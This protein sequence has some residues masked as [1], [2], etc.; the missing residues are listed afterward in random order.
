MGVTEL[1]MGAAGGGVRKGKRVICLSEHIC[2]I[3]YRPDGCSRAGGAGGGSIGVGFL[4][5]ICLDFH[6]I[7]MK[8]LVFAELRTHRDTLG[9]EQGIR[10]QPSEWR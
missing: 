7:G 8:G 5:K 4:Q 6:F 2:F 3:S 1:A 9:W 10:L